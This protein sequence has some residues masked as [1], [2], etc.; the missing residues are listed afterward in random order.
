MAIT[1][2]IIGRFTAKSTKFPTKPMLGYHHIRSMLLHYLGKFINQT[3]CTFHVHKTCFK[4]NFYHLSNRYLSDFM[5]ISTKVSTI[6]TNICLETLFTFQQD[7]APARCAR[8][9]TGL[10]QHE[11]PDFIPPGPTYGYLTART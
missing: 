4:C 5:K 11:T 6:C 7:S 1:L 3:F 2:S 9:T 8:E 10:L